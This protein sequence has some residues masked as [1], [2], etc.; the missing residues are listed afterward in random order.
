VAG[1]RAE[2]S[3][4]CSAAALSRS[5]AGGRHPQDDIGLYRGIAEIL[6]IQPKVGPRAH[7][8]GPWRDE[9]N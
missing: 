9:R 5:R 6:D 3:N 7:L 2:G 1:H 8:D 4:T